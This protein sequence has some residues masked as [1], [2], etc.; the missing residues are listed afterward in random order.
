MSPVMFR[1]ILGVS[2]WGFALLGTL[3]IAH[4]PG[5]WGHSICGIWG[6]GPPLQ[7]LVACHLSW[8]LVLLPFGVWGRLSCSERW[9]RYLG[10]ALLLMSL[11]AVS[12]LAIHERLTWWRSATDFQREFFWERIQ[13]SLATHVDLPIVQLLLVG[14]LLVLPKTE[15]QHR[16]DAR[17]ISEASAPSDAE[18]ASA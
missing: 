16:R 5:N 12:A 18:T 4:W 9:L 7:A 3:S 1:F 2:A 17:M 6:C 10:C 8:L 15:K 11:V 14:I 13:F